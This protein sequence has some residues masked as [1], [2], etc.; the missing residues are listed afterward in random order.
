MVCKEGKTKIYCG[1]REVSAKHEVRG[2]LVSDQTLVNY[3]ICIF[4]KYGSNDLKMV[5]LTVRRK[6]TE[7]LRK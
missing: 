2:H 5:A 1:Q 3:N 6:Q 7:S 4:E